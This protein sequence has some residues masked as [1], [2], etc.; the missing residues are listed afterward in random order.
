M[1]GMREPKEL[2]FSDAGPI[3]NNPFLP[4]LIYKAAIRLGG[5]PPADIEQVFQENGWPPQWRYGIYPFHHYHST[6]HEALGVAR[7]GAKVKLGGESGETV[8]LAPGDV[9]VL[10]AG[11]G[12]RC[13]ESTDDFLVVGAY[14][15]GQEWDLI[16][17][18]EPGKKAEAVKRIAEVPLPENDPVLGRDGPLVRLWARK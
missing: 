10:P 16:R 6:A 12:H 17:A 7:G 9:V 3:P 5:D 11:T 13:L 14:P 1:H 18:D 8:E 15:P 2:R 4:A